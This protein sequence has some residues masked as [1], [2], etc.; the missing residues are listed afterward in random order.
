MMKNLNALIFA[1][2]CSLLLSAPAMATK[3]GFYLGASIGDATTDYNQVEGF[4]F[5]DSDTAWKAFAGY[6]LLQF[7]AIEASYRD[8]GEVNGVL[9]PLGSGTIDTTGYDIAGLVG[10]P[11][12]PVY[13]FGKAGVMYWD[14]K[15][16]QGVSYDGTDYLLGVGGS[17]DI[18]PI[19][20]R[21][22][23]EY[24]DFLD[25]GFMYSV[26]AAWRF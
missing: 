16:N 3:G 22:E 12:G 9:S 24:L 14:S 4:K 8:L 6:H 15:T 23:A 2:V 26:G 1:A 17:I 21:A 10:L 25:A 20:L 19:Q 5:D 18:G 13:L 7:F 11:L